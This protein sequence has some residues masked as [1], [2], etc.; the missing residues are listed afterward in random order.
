M[1]DRPGL[2]SSILYLEFEMWQ[3][4]ALELRDILIQT[5]IF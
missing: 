2:R 5:L 4:F 3:K 1:F